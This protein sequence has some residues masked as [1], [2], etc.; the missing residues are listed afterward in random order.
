M[1]STRISG[2]DLAA[3]GSARL[4]RMF[5]AIEPPAAWRERL[6]ELQDAL[7]RAA[8]DYFRYVDPSVMHLTVVFLGN[9]PAAAVA[10]IGQALSRAAARIEPFTLGAAGLGSFGSPQAPRVLWF[11]VH[12]PTGRLQRLRGEVERELDDSGIDFD[13][14]PLVP[15]LTL[16]RARRTGG[17]YQAGREA[18]R[19][20]PFTVERVTLFE[21][22]LGPGGPRHTARAFARLAET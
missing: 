7:R 15:H 1:H 8:P 16:G 13:R 4:L 5:V 19:L 20:A 22:D 6:A 21:S 2:A 3:A 9:Q 14:K 18:V 11:G 10:A 12:E 17:R